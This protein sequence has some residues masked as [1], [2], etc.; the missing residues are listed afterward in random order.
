MEKEQSIEELIIRAQNDEKEAF[1]KLILKIKNDLY[2]IA[3]MRLYCEDDIEDAVQETIIEVYKNIKKLRK[4][5]LFKTWVIKI[6]INRCN[7]IYKK[8]AK[9]N[10]LEYLDENFHEEYSRIEGDN[11]G[12]LDFYNLLKKLN[13]KERL[14]LTLFYL[15]DFTTKEIS[16]IVKE[17]E[18][19]IRNRIARARKKL[20]ECIRRENNGEN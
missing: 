15:S 19:T 6:L 1:K 12:N 17:P 20:K 10:K 18:S 7:K 14:A 13:Y 2:K 9:E 16:K 4:I 8:S 11:I 5:E 3:R